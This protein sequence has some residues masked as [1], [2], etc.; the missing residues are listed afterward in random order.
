[1]GPT[2]VVLAQPGKW[3]L[4]A[5]VNNV[6]SFAGQSS[7]PDVNQMLFQYFINYNL[8]KGWYV[9]SSPIL[10]SNWQATGG[11]RWIVPFGGGVGRIMRLGFQP[12]NL[13][14]QFYGNAVHPS[15]ASPLGLRLQIA[16]LFPKLS[17]EQERMMLE[18]RLKRMQEEQPKR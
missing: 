12:V 7:R 3:T 10:T 14:A 5:L 9:T 4:G 18:Q 16:F 13:T 1:M 11:G 17:K 15:G 8:N 6:W 2:V